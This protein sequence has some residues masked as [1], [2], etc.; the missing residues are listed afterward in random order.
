MSFV[1]NPYTQCIFV[2][3]TFNIVLSSS[4]YWLYSISLP[5]KYV[6]PQMDLSEDTEATMSTDISMLAPKEKAINRVITK[7]F[8]KFHCNVR[9]SSQLRSLFI[10]KLHR[11]GKYFIHWVVAKVEKN[12]TKVERI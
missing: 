10:S 11:M 12:N 2:S 6:N 8:T 3:K 4:S 5:D 9:I 1:Q 7:L